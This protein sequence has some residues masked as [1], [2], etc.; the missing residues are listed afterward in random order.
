MAGMKEDFYRRIGMDYHNRRT[1]SFI[2]R[3]VR[4]EKEANLRLQL[5][6]EYQA[7]RSNPEDGTR[8]AKFLLTDVCED[9]NL[10]KSKDGI[11]QEIEKIAAMLTQAEWENI[12]FSAVDTCMVSL[13]TKYEWEGE[14]RNAYVQ[15]ASGYQCYEIGEHSEGMETSEFIRTIRLTKAEYVASVFSFL[16]ENIRVHLSTEDRK[17]LLMLG[18]CLSGDGAFAGMRKESDKMRFLIDLAAQSP[19][20]FSE[21]VEQIYTEQ[22]LSKLTDG[23]LDGLIINDVNTLLYDG[24]FRTGQKEGGKSR[25]KDRG[26]DML[27]AY[28][29]E[30]GIEPFAASSRGNVSVLS[31]DKNES[32]GEYYTACNQLRDALNQEKRDT[33]FIPL[34][35]DAQFGGGIFLVGRKHYHFYPDV[36]AQMKRS[37]GFCFVSF[38]NVAEGSAYELDTEDFDFPTMEEAVSWFYMKFDTPEDQLDEFRKYNRMV[39]KNCPDVFTKFFD[40]PVKVDASEKTDDVAKHEIEASRRELEAAYQQEKEREQRK[41]I[42]RKCNR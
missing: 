18:R 38:V 36:A 15:L 19:D 5:V 14:K 6:R 8:F 9:K 22:S 23:L 26:M 12:D 37:C 27:D 13:Y 2:Y 20:R 29:K 39:P 25:K 41:R 31:D 34:V 32:Y 16:L 40:Q 30:I 10:A 35:V 17:R 28:M 3:Y 11:K 4:Q 21:A 24:G 1:E 7:W 33:V 42:Q